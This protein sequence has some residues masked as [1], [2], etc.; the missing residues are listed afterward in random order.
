MK[1]TLVFILVIIF[2]STSYPITIKQIDIT[3]NDR[4]QQETILHFFYENQTNKIWTETELDSALK[5]FKERLERT[6]WYS[7]IE[8]GKTINGDNA[9]IQ[10]SLKEKSSY[11]IWAGNLYLGL[12]K[13]DLWGKGKVIEFEAGPIEKKI[14]IQ[15]WMFNYSDVFFSVA[16]GAEDYYTYTYITNAYNQQEL[17][18]NVGNATVGTLLFPDTFIDI[19]TRN[20][21]IEN[22]NGTSIT[23]Y[24]TAGLKFAYDRRA[25]YPSAKNGENTDIGI[26]Y[27]YP[28]NMVQIEGS[29]QYYYEFIKNWVLAAKL[30]AGYTSGDVPVYAKF[31]L[32][33]I[34]GLRTLSQFSGMIGND[35]YDMHG[36][37][38]WAFWDVIPFIIFDMQL[39]ALALFDFGEA[40]DSI[41]NM[42]NPH[43][44]YGAGLRI[45]LD[46]FCVRAEVG[47]DETGNTTVLSSFTL[48]F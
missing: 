35:C 26:N 34:D 28:Y 33:T 31:D 9:E 45:Y 18:R 10:V 27:I 15:D 47:I 39:E 43:Y 24:H 25:G 1:K 19:N 20:Y 42:G 13:Y 40:R 38:R 8:I 37:I 3:G 12:S 23:S 14:T 7:A 4:S 5:R 30:H 48:P 6:G 44:V 16:L 29:V 17:V 46:A 32:R 22:T 21:W 2:Y 36:E 41:G 11:S